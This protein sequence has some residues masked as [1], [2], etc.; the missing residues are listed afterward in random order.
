MVTLDFGK[1]VRRAR[2]IKNPMLTAEQRD[3]DAEITVFLKDAAW[4]IDSKQEPICSSSDSNERG[5]PMLSGLHRLV[6]KKVNSTS[7]SA[8]A[9]DLKIVFAGGVRLLVFC[10]QTDES[11]NADNYSIRNQSGAVVVGP[12]GRI[13]FEA[14]A[15]PQ[16]GATS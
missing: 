13:V 14:R 8:P 6:G 5:G 3:F 10:V 16:S 15:R 7:V 12:K 11:S 2:P 4:R 9:G 1:R